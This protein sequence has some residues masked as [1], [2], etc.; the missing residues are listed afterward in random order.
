M[1]RFLFLLVLFIASSESS[2]HGH[3]KFKSKLIHKKIKNQTPPPYH[4]SE[5]TYQWV[6]KHGFNPNKIHDAVSFAAQERFFEIMLEIF[7]D[8]DL[9]KYY[10][11]MLSNS[12][13]KRRLYKLEEIIKAIESGLKYHSDKQKSCAHKISKIL[14]NDPYFQELVAQL[15]QTRKRILK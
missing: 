6:R 10:Q 1:S 9:C 3:H 2:I 15:K 7:L 13:E 8:D 11:Q 5:I 4:A 14:D 12:I